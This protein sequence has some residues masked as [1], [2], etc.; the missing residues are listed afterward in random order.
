MTELTSLMCP[1]HLLLPGRCPKPAL[2]LQVLPL[3]QLLQH[4]GHP[5]RQPTL[6]EVRSR[7]L[8]VL[9]RVPPAGTGQ[10]G[11][12]GSWLRRDCLESSPLS[13][14]RRCRRRSAPPIPRQKNQAVKVGWSV[15]NSNCFVSSNPTQQR[16]M[17][18]GLRCAPI[19]GF[20]LAH[21]SRKPAGRCFAITQFMI[22]TS[23]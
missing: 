23:C 15:L 11:C 1:A 19:A 10:C 5:T 18:S 2:L 21:Q 12:R 13:R 20:R 6:E 14:L 22:G 17:R 16:S 8:V 7:W 9:P 4:G 3:L